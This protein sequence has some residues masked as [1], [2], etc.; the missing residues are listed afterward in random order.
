VF[1]GSA[2]GATTSLAHV[3]LGGPSFADHARDL[4]CRS[5]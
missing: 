5:A 1:G 3:A 2:S 4:S